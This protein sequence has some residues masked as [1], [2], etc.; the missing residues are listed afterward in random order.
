M[1]PSP[2]R[3]T[4]KQHRWPAL[5]LLG[6]VL[7]AACAPAET[8]PVLPLKPLPK[9]TTLQQQA[10]FQQELDQLGIQV[11]SG[12]SFLYEG[13]DLNAFQNIINRFYQEHPGYCPLE[14]AFFLKENPYGLYMTVTAK[15]NAVAALIY[16][17]R[18]KPKIT[19][20]VLEGQSKELLGVTNC[21]N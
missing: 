17:Q 6:V 15:G 4:P 8:A 12:T 5:T 21:S 3:G 20:S 10:V 11:T 1:T 19:Y 13:L 7:L 18:Q 2:S 14:N 9:E 16:D